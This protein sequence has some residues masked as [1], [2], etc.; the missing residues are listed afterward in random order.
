[1]ELDTASAAVNPLSENEDMD[2]EDQA[3]QPDQPVDTLS[4]TVASDV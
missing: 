2:T 4:H 3:D 1:M